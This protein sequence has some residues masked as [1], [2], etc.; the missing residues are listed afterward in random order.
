MSSDIHTSRTLAEYSRCV[1]A[2]RRRGCGRHNGKVIYRKLVYCK[3]VL[4]VALLKRRPSSF[5]KL[6]LA[7]CTTRNELGH[8]LL[9]C[10]K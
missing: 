1:A 2:L 9:F 6:R 3:L 4:V 5:L 10:T 8:V 7:L